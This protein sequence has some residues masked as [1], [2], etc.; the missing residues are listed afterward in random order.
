MAAS[1]TLDTIERDAYRRSYSDGIIDTFVGVSLLWIGI[2]WI[3]LP[4]FAG[5]A[6]VFPAIFVTPLL[7]GRKKFV[8]QRAGYVRWS[9]PRRSWERRNLMALLV[10]GTLMFVVGVGLFLA[11]N[12][13]GD[14]SLFDS[15]GPGLLAFLLA[16]MAVGMAFLLDAWRMLAYAAVLIIGGIVASVADANPGWPLLAAGT[17]IAAVGAVMIVRFVHSYPNAAA[18]DDS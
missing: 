15:I 9:E 12:R 17:A 14:F 2:A 10:A 1:Q 8:E 18:D 7:A 13:S 4:D 11:V 16:L 3:W 5:L 6:G